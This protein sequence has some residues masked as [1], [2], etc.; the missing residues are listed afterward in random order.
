MEFGIYWKFPS[1][2]R[3]FRLKAFILGK[4]TLPFLL[5]KGLKEYRL[6]LF[7]VSQHTHINSFTCMWQDMKGENKYNHTGPQH[8]FLLWIQRRRCRNE[9]EWLQA[10]CRGR[11]NLSSEVNLAALR[12]QLRGKILQIALFPF[13]MRQTMCNGI[14]VTEALSWMKYSL[15]ARF[16]RY[17]TYFF[18]DANAAETLSAGVVLMY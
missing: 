2:R 9:M 5:C 3:L 12:P 4:Q 11:W 7:L 13:V 16:Q 18:I 15:L 6:L 10:N 8:F 17:F 1:E 14:L